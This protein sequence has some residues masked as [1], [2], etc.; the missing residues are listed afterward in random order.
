MLTFNIQKITLISSYM[1][2]LQKK[3][4]RVSLYS[5]VFGMLAYKAL[6]NVT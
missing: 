4:E 6:G 5:I 3:N 1:G 2:V